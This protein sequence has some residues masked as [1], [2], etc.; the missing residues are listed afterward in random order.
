L[1]A[2]VRAAAE[3]A[4]VFFSTHQISEV[5][6]IA[7]HVFIMNRGQLVFESPIEEMRAH[8]RRI[9]VAF[10][11]RVPVE[12]MSHAGAQRARVQ[13]HV[14]SFVVKENVESITRRAHSLGALSVDVQPIS[15]R[16]VFLESVEGACS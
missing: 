12:E 9:H 10:P 11:G 3:G 14:L 13:D 5:E 8:H 15:L 7:D 1:E 4:T 2:V 16:E 6:R